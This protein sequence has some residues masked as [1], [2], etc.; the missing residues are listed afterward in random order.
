MKLCPKCGNVYEDAM[1]FCPSDGI[2]LVV[3]PMPLPSEFMSDEEEQTVIRVPVSSKP[4]I[5]A[6]IPDLPLEQ[7]SIS[8]YS[9]YEPGIPAAKNESQKG[10]LKYALILLV[11]LLVGGFFVLAVVGAGYWFLARG[12]RASNE[13][14]ANTEEPLPKT[15][16]KPRKSPTPKPTENPHSIPAEGIDDSL[17]NGRVIKAAA[18]RQ[19]P[20]A[21]AKRVATLPKGDRLRIIER[22]APTSA[23][24][25]VSC[26]HG[27]EG[28]MHGN[29]IEY[30]DSKE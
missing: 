13:N 12:E 27:E 5:P 26:E 21:G 1:A 18:L 24:Y 25:R 28:W 29:D 10:C 30:V 15:P 8:G 4:E 22:R 16:G 3:E 6:A 23:W 9:R 11:G 7:P 2:A 20:N 17:L 19:T 14:T